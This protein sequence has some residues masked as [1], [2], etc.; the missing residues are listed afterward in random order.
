MTH[1]IKRIKNETSSS[2]GIWETDTEQFVGYFD[3]YDDARN[4]IRFLKRGGGY[5]DFHPAFVVANLEKGE[6]DVIE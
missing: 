1:E 6:N 3:D 2:F 5:G 4:H